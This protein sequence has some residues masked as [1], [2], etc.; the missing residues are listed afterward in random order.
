M[1]VEGTIVSH[2]EN[3]KQTNKKTNMQPCEISKY[4]CG[5]THLVVLLKVRYHDDGGNV[6]VPDHAPQ[7]SKGGRYGSLRGN[8]AVPIVVALQACVYTHYK[9]W[10]NHVHTY[11]HL[12]MLQ[13]T[14]LLDSF[15]TQN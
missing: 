9:M 11:I 14:I 8:V 4:T 12:Y 1:Y 10:I 6:E 2:E 3:I 5:P 13:G 15:A 7:V